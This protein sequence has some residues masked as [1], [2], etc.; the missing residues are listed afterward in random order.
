MYCR[1]CSR[2][3]FVHPLPATSSYTSWDG[4]LLHLPSRHNTKN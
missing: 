2:A 3:I 4:W 1:A